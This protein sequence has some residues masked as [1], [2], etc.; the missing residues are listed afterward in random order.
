MTNCGAGSES[1]CASNE[2]AGGTYFRT[3]DDDGT[4]PVDGGTVLAPDGGPA[5]LADPATVS[6]LRLDKYEVTVGRFRQFVAAWNGGSGWLPAA[7]S[8]K[9][10]HLNG[11]QGLVDVGATSIDGGVQYEPGWLASDDSN[12]A[13]TDTNLSS[14]A[15]FGTWTPTAGSTENL[16]I[17]CV[18]WWE[19]YAFC[20][21]DGGF[22][23]SEAEWE[24]AAAGGSQQLEYP[25]GS[26]DPGTGNQYA[27]Y[28]CYYPSGSGVCTGE[29]NIA[30][31]GTPTAGAGVWGQLDLAGNA[32]EWNLDSFFNTSYVDPCSDCAYLTVASLGRVY[33]GGKFTDPLMWVRPPSGHGAPESTRNFGVGLRCART[34]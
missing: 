12:V 25:W 9:H 15:P 1:C 33:R 3:Y 10:T 8:G 7:G 11:G 31:V 13:P 26:T 16:P 30:P 19:S 32:L 18:N 21:W 34:P 24:Y 17:T 22:L 27:I 14:C 23:P 4:P 5:G 29:T 28:G 6:S 20:I 2:V